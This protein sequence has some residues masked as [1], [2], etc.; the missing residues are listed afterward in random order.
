MSTFDISSVQLAF[1]ALLITAGSVQWALFR[2]VTAAGEKL[3]PVLE[4]TKR[5]LENEISKQALVAANALQEHR[6]LS[7]AAIAK[8]EANTAAALSK[9]DTDIER[10]KREAVRREDMS[11]IES[12]LTAMLVKME[13][14]VDQITDKLMGFSLLE[15]QVQTI[16]LRLSDN[17]RRT[18]HATQPATAR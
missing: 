8:L 10:L 2:M 7:S 5:E 13:N 12:R 16:D 3:S 15:K 11:A 14:K 9:L 6:A 18:E 4:A 17:I 1:I